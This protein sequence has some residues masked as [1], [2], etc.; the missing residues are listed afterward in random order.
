M[1][2]A[3]I[4][5]LT[6]AARCSSHAGG[7]RRHD[8]GRVTSISCVSAPKAHMRPQYSRPQSTVDATVNVA[9][10]YQA[11]LYL[12]IGKSRLRS[13]KTL[14]IVMSWLFQ[15]PSRTTQATSVT[16][17]RRLLLRKKL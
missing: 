16:Y 6:K 3:R 4:P 14:T 9:R 12:K 5:Y 11:R 17:L 1:A 10:R 15:N 13:P 8:A 2:A 7:S